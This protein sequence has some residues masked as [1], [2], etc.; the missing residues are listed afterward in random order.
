MLAMVVWLLRELPNLRDGRGGAQSLSFKQDMAGAFAGA[1]PLERWVVVSVLGWLPLVLAGPFLLLYAHEFKGADGYTLGPMGSAI[2]AAGVLLGV[3]LGHLA[4]R[5]GRKWT[6]FSLVPA[7]YR[8]L[9]RLVVG[10]GTMAIVIAAG[11]WGA[12]QL[13]LV[14]ANAMGNE[15]VAFS[16]IGRWQGVLALGRGLVSV[17][18]PLLSG[19]CG[20]RWGRRPSSCCRLC[21]I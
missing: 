9:A 4:D 7:D 1:P 2:T 16:Q 11:L 18:P 17:P 12:S 3:P 8:V 19:F 10:T 5:V 21:W 13:T 6:L 15:L 14:I 20:A